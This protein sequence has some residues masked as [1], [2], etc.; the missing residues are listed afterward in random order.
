MS[1]PSALVVFTDADC[2]IVSCPFCQKLHK[3]GASITANE[4]RSSHCQKGEYILGDVL[5]DKEV[6]L[7]I[8]Y[9]QREKERCRVRKQK[10]KAERNAP[11]TES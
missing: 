5:S 3:H 1:R 6:A 9:R 11:K 10:E 2:V 7:A 4:S 8:E